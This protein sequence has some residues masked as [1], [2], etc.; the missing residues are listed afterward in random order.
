MTKT[1]RINFRL[2][3][4]LRDALQS[5]AHRYDRSEA[6]VIREAVWQLLE[7]KGYGRPKVK[8]GKRKK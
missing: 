7:S 4:D 5:Y 1:D 6:D 2:G 8:G 3:P